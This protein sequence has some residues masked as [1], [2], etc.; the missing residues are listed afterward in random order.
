[1]SP[2]GLA[3]C[4]I[5]SWVLSIIGVGSVGLFRPVWNNLGWGERYLALIQVVRTTQDRS[6]VGFSTFLLSCKPEKTWD[7]VRSSIFSALLLLICKLWAQ[8]SF[9]FFCSHPVVK[10]TQ[11]WAST[12]GSHLGHEN[13]PG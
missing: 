12:S 5:S 13:N 3:L 8:A 1:V 11:D 7:K 6:S 4:F 10:K 9:Q 2:T